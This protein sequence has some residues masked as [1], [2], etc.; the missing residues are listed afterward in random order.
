VLKVLPRERKG[1]R[2]HA[3]VCRG[4]RAAADRV[5]LP[6]MVSRTDPASW[7]DDDDEK[8]GGASLGLRR[9][10]SEFD[11]PSCSANNPFDEF[12]NGDEVR[13]SW[14]GLEFRALVD[15]EGA[16]RLKEL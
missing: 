4:G 16:L 10:F 8:K 13:C 14:C 15:D 7:E 12:G 5:R 6:P 11:C 3:R 9:R 2:P 1:N